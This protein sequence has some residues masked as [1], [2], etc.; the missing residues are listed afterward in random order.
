MIVPRQLLRFC[1]TALPFALSAAAAP[2]ASAQEGPALRWNVTADAGI[3][4]QDGFDGVR[5]GRDMVSYGLRVTAARDGS[6]H[7]WVGGARFVRPDFECVPGLDCND[8]GWLARAGIAVPLSRESDGSGLGAEARTGAGAAFAEET[9]FSY[10][11]GFA[12]LWHGIPRI[13]P[14][15]EFRWEHVTGINLTMFAA[16]V[17]LDL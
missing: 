11:I 10:L 17:R 14:M 8:A 15:M 1:F 9:S 6:L 2:S 13:A 4:V 16:G 3:S 12:L 5:F 7:P